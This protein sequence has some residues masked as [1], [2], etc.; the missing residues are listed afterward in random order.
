MTLNKMS[1]QI[2]ELIDEKVDEKEL[3]YDDLQSIVMDLSV[4]IDKRL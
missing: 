2:C 4:P 3:D 1:T